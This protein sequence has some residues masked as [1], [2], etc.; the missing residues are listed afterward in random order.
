MPSWTEI[1]SQIFQLVLLPLLGIVIKY[2]IQ[3]INTK[4]SEIQANTNNELYKKYIAMLTATIT[5]VV[6][7]TNQTYVDTLKEQGKFDEE[8]QKAA[9]QKTYDTVM[10]LLTDEAKTYLNTAIA[11]LQTYILTC[12]ESEVKNQKMINGK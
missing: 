5:N 10:S 11:D 6:V 1:F 4:S 9:L 12:I 8:A 2:V 3:F 7:A